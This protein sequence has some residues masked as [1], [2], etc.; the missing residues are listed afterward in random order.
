[1]HDELHDS[2]IS[3]LIGYMKLELMVVQGQKPGEIVNALFGS[4]ASIE[5]SSLTTMKNS[6]T[7]TYSPSSLSTMTE[8]VSRTTAEHSKP[9]ALR[10]PTTSA[11]AR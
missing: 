11:T 9:K 7:W 1:M 4:V 10:W 6:K 8:K 2:L 3:S 5:T